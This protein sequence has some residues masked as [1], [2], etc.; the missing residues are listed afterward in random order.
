M[1]RRRRKLGMDMPIDRR[2]FLNGA[3]MSAAV[4]AMALADPALAAPGPQ[5]KPGTYPP[6][7]NG[8]RGSH[9]GSF[10][11]AHS[12]RDGTFWSTAEKMHDTEGVYDLVIVGAG[13]SGL[14]AAQFYRA[15]K[16]N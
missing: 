2:D 14:S 10:D 7:L 15:A 8:I 1:D 9:P 4:S 11:I 5:D 3:A 12:V 16:P 13:I 6:A